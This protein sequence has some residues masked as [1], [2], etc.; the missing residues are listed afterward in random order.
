M[1]TIAEA[2]EQL[3]AADV[4]VLFIDTCVLL[5]VVRAPFRRLPVCIRGALDLSSLQSR[6]AC[7]LV[8]SSMIQSE[9]EKHQQPVADE[10][11]RH[12]TER[13]LDAVA[14][15][16]A[17][18][19]VNLSLSFASPSYQA[20]GLAAR[21]RDLSSNLLKS[22]IHLHPSDET[23]ARASKRTLA[24]RRPAQK[25][26][27]LQ[28]CIILEEY[29]EVCRQLQIA[30][31]SKKKV[32]CSS[33]LRDYQEGKNLHPTLQVEFES[34]GLEFTNALHWAANELDNR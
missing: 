33:N 30:Q 1:P 4:P 6:L 5:D 3:V 24:G 29:L 8:A 34:A 26:G 12:L 2:A 14:F 13:D 28:D 10:L 17:C 20:A 16:D 23:T 27:G 32:F 18:G 15:H 11:D 31:F 25:G 21:L 9:W 19:L 22:A 7:Q